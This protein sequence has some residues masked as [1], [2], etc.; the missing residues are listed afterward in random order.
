[1]VA[2]LAASAAQHLRLHPPKRVEPKA[3]GSRHAEKAPAFSGVPTLVHGGGEARARRSP[4]GARDSR[5]IGRAS[6]PSCAAAQPS[7]VARCAGTERLWRS[8]L[9]R[10]SRA[11]RGEDGRQTTGGTALAVS[12]DNAGASSTGAVCKPHRYDHRPA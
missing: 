5:R 10:E 12:G 11:V 1:M 4:A 7:L 9:R 6:S 2:M 8:R 3:R